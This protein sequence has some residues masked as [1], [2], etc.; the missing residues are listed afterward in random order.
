M[1]CKW[2]FK[3]IYKPNGE[4]ERHKARLAAKGHTQTEGLDY[5]ET[6]SPVVK[7]TTVRTLLFVA[8]TKNWFLQQLDVNTDFLHG[9]L[10][11]E[12][13]VELPP[14]LSVSDPNMVCK[15]EKSLY[16]LKQASRQWNVKLTHVH[17]TL[18]F[19]QSKVDYSLFTKS[20]NTGFTDHSSLC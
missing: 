18:G 14:C 2:V 9:D 10:N 15:L 12:V 16:G 17:I 13:Y 1:G 8:V 19:S 5:N 20:S 11:Q 4:I 3:V 7:M 6:F